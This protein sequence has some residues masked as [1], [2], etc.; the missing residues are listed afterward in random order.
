MSLV[1][2]SHYITIGDELYPVNNLKNHKYF[3]TQSFTKLLTGSPFESLVPNLDEFWGPKILNLLVITQ[4]YDWSQ[5]YVDLQVERLQTL[6]PLWEKYEVKI[7]IDLTVAAEVDEIN[8]DTEYTDAMTELATNVESTC[9]LMSDFGW[10]YMGT[11]DE[12]KPAIFF[13]TYIDAFYTA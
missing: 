5:D 9:A 6:F 7:W 4:R 10:L 1:D 8:S 11:L 13:Q 2:N 12:K 3:N